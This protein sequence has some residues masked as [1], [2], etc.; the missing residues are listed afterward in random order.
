M[1][2]SRHYHIRKLH[3]S[4]TMCQ[5]MVEIPQN[6]CVFQCRKYRHRVRK[7]GTYKKLC[8]EDRALKFRMRVDDEYGVKMQKNPS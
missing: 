8:D 7:Y 4:A 6:K 3:I 5:I 1:P 2:Q